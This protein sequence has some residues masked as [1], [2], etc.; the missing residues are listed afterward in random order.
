MGRSPTSVMQD[1]VKHRPLT[2]VPRRRLVV[3]GIYHHKIPNRSIRP[4]LFGRGPR[5]AD[6]AALVADE[7]GSTAA[8]PRQ[9]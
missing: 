6:L 3:I 2:G 5:L 8:A 1:S 4:L 9:P 7:T